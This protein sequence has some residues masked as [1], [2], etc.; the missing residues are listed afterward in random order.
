MCNIGFLE[1]NFL[2]FGVSKDKID[3]QERLVDAG[4]KWPT[5]QSVYEARQVIVFAKFYGKF[6][7]HYAGNV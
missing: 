1:A 6:I 7:K 5:L 3:R 4:P 2:G